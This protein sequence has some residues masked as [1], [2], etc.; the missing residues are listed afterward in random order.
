MSTKKVPK[1]P[2]FYYCKNCDYNTCR[3]SQ[4]DRHLLTSKHIKSTNFQP[5]SSESSNFLNK[6]NCSCGKEYKEKSGLWRHKKICK[7]ENITDNKTQENE[8][9]SISPPDDEPSLK[10]M[11]I[12]VVEHNQEMMK[13]LQ[14]TIPKIGNT[15]NNTNNFNLNFFLN[16]QC[17]DALNIMDFIDQLKVKLSDLDMVGRIGY[18]EGISKIFIRGLKELDVFKRPIHCSDLKREILY[19]KDQDS[20]EKDNEEKKKLKTAI[21]FIAAKNLKQLNDWKEEYP[22]SDDY[23]S[24][25]HMEY[26]NIIINATG[27]STLEEDDKNF[28]KIIKNVAKEVTIEKEKK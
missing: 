5:F 11:F 6:F 21:K 23:D 26:H 9:I 3:K 1:V 14:E 2:K 16:E 25:K 22:E 10:E 15:T 28:N 19:V 8:I 24:K 27:G 12:K 7:I 17:K 18:T 13:L 20:W 4:Y